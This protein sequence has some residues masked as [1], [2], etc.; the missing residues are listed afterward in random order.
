MIQFTQELPSHN[1]ARGAVPMTDEEISV[2]TNMKNRSELR[3]PDQVSGTLASSSKMA[4]QRL[5]C[6]ATLKA[7]ALDGAA[8]LGPHAWPKTENK[9]EK[10]CPQ[11]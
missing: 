10:I 6:T 7:P 9:D 2:S 1:D 5:R 4:R 8:N 11:A 3:R